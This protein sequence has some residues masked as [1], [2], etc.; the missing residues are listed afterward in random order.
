MLATSPMP[1]SLSCNLSANF[2]IIDGN[3]Q[4]SFLSIQPCPI[5]PDHHR[6]RSV[7]LSGCSSSRSSFSLR[8]ASFVSQAETWLAE[9]DQGLEEGEEEKKKKKISPYLAVSL[10]TIHN[11][12]LGEMMEIESNV[13]AIQCGKYMKTL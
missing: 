10:I 1:N 5:P 9:E 7:V 11:Y 6:L 3:F 4:N 13:Q 8:K 12:K 2:T